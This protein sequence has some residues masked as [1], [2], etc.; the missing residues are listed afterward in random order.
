MEEQSRPQ[1]L[2]GLTAEGIQKLEKLKAEHESLSAALQ[3][4]DSMPAHELEGR[5]R[6]LQDKDAE[7]RRFLREL[8]LDV[9]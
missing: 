6:Q 3:H 7:I 5:M 8:G 2:P 9:G 4:A 1:V